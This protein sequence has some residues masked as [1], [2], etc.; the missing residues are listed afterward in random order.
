MRAH[1]PW[2]TA[3]AGQKGWP[4]KTGSTV[5][6]FLKKC[7]LRFCSLHEIFSE[8][9]LY[10]IL[11]IWRCHCQC[12]CHWQLR[13][14]RRWWPMILE[15]PLSWNQAVVDGCTPRDCR[16]R[17]TSASPTD[18]SCRSC[19]TVN[20]IIINYV[21]NTGCMKETEGVERGSDFY[22][23][24]IIIFFLMIHIMHVL[25]T[26]N[27]CVAK[28]NFLLMLTRTKNVFYYYLL[29]FIIIRVESSRHL[30]EY[31]CNFILFVFRHFNF[32]RGI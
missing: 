22:I 3:F 24:I 21:M 23:I 7:S 15:C 18:E 6:T 5:N 30:F 9:I 16:R 8:W 27:Y 10:T 20:D 4:L 13:I 32:V 11:F 14:P 28:G 31:L 12:V 1:L 29:L 26:G 2:D 19:D 17:M 25:C